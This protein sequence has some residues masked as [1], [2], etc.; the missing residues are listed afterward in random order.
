MRIPAKWMLHEQLPPQRYSINLLPIQVPGVETIGN[1]HT[2]FR[3]NREDTQHSLQLR[4]RYHDQPLARTGPTA[5]ALRPD[6]SIFPVDWWS[7]LDSLEH[8]QLCAMNVSNYRDV[9]R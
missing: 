1:K 3:I 6:L 5:H 7:L 9:R 8:E 2:A 4:L